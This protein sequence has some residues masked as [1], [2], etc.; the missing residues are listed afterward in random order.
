[1]H[2][3]ARLRPDLVTVLSYDDTGS[4]GFP[5]MTNRPIKSVTNYREYMTPF[6][7]TN[8]GTGE[9]VYIYN[10]RDRWSKGANR[11]CSILYNVVRRIKTKADADCSEI[12]LG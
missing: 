7:L 10:T 12:E 5:R 11:L 4:F 8:H 9:N 2:S 6:N 3:L 1:M